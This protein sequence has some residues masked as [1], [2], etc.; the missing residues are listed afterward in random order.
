MALLLYNRLLDGLAMVA[1]VLLLAVTVGIGL[2]VGARYLFASPI[3]WMSEFVQ[4]SMLLIL[5]LSIG[6]LTRER[7]HVAV[8]I[9]YDVLPRRSRRILEI[10]AAL[11]SCAISAFVGAW[12]TVSA[13]DNFVRGVETEGIYPFPRYWLIGVI[14]LGLLLAA[15]E[16]LRSAITMMTNPQVEIRQID[17]EVVTVVHQDKPQD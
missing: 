1:A 11:L 5:F 9:L 2:D 8:E 13:W 6:W 7:G 3:G 12:A 14:A 4:H 16:F 17:A 15:I 10:V